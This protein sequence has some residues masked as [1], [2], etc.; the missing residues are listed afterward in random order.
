MDRLT[1]ARWAFII[2]LALAVIIA[3]VTDIDEWATW[4][5]ILLALFAGWEFVT[6]EQ[7]QHFFLVGISLMFLSQTLAEILADFPSIGKTLL[8]LLTS[9]AVFFGFLV[10]SL[11][12][13]NIIVWVTGR[14]ISN[15]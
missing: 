15:R 5:M 10:I 3:L 9:L 1:L 4:I 7:E 2:G 6:E 13:R 8:A 14:P 11:I 12:V